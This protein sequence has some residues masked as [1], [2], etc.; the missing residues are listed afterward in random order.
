MR[1]TNGRHY[2]HKSAENFFSADLC[3]ND[4][5]IKSVNGLEMPC[6]AFS[7][8]SARR[9]RKSSVKRKRREGISLPAE[10]DEGYAPSTAQVF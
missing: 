4:C 7:F 6:T 1:G 5:Y 8:D 3:Y 10:S 9:K 2:K